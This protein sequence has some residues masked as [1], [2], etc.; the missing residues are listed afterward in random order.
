MCKEQQR[1]PLIGGTWHQHETFEPDRI[2]PEELML[3]PSHDSETHL[4]AYTYCG[5]LRQWNYI[6][7]IAKGNVDE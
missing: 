4:E 7:M 2:N 5:I 6:A 3:M 1:V